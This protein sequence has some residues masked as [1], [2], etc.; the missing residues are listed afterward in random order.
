MG[1]VDMRSIKIL[2]I[3]GSVLTHKGGD[4][5][6][7]DAA[8]S[9]AISDI[10]HWRADQPDQGLV[11]LTGGGSFGHPLAARYQI[12]APTP[13]KDTLGFLQTTTNMHDMGTQI[14]RRFLDQGVPVFPLAP[15]A[16]FLTDQGRIVESHLDPLLRALDNGLIPFLWGDAV[17]DRSHTYR[18]LSADQMIMVLGDRLGSGDLLFGTNV[19]GIYTR[20]PHTDP[21]AEQIPTVDDQNY[22]RVLESLSEGRAVDVTGGMRGKIEEIH[23]VAKRPLTC[24]IYNALSAGNTYRALCGERIGTRL[25]FES[26]THQETR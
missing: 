25:A 15:S 5:E 12:N 10:Q 4:S 2:K 21:T 17:F 8:L 3:G 23:A 9:N 7:N 26:P 6:L 22:R 24:I 20:D 19:D 14:T 1:K 16:I 11:F 13:A 18:I